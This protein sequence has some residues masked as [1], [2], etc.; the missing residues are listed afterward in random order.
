[1]TNLPSVRKC[2]SSRIYNSRAAAGLTTAEQLLS[3]GVDREA[4]R[5]RWPWAVEYTGFD[6]ELVYLAADLE[7]QRIGGEA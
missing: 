3:Y 7:S 4:V 2:P 5:H 1:M 6:G